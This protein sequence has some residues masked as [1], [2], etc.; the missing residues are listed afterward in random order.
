MKN[1]ILGS[2]TALLT[3]AGLALAQ[4]PR[5]AAP[6]PT[7]EAVRLQPAPSTSAGPE[8]EKPAPTLPPAGPPAEVAAPAPAPAGACDD[9]CVFAA[10]PFCYYGP[11]SVEDE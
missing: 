1:G 11:I 2:V 8:G 6:V 7:A 10:P 5:T 4:A 3:G 9:G